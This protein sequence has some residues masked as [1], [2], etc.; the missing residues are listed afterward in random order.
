MI[1][2]GREYPASRKALEE[3]CQSYWFPI[4]GFLRR[5]GHD[6]QDA[7]DLTQGFFAYLLKQSLLRKA[8][9][10][11]GRFRNFL[12]G[13]L[14][15]FVSNQQELKDARKRGAQY[16]IVSIDEQTAEGL[17]AHEPATDGTPDKIFEQRWALKVLEQAMERLREEYSRAGMKAIFEASEP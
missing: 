16:K 11:R 6:R 17:Y 5:W 1:V 15:N 2:A 12:L 13:V 7:H 9:P 4:Y 3:L 14:K 8:D 10:E